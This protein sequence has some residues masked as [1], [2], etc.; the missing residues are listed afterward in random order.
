MRKCKCVA[1]LLACLLLVQTALAGSVYAEEKTED[2]GLNMDFKSAEAILVEKE[3]GTVL[4]EK[5]S[6][7]KRPIAS[8]TKIMTMLL[9]MEAID[10]GALSFDDIVTVS[11]R[12][13]SMGG[14]TIYLETGEQMSVR[15]IL[16]G[17][18]VM[19][20]NDGCVAIR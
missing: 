7:E 20:A 8:V 4:F 3:T 11:E 15:D 1:V 6:H 2:T 10:S 13:K 18:A 12:A 17:I 5:N 19:S 14:S 16:K 9:T